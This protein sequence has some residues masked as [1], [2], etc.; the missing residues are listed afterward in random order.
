MEIH[1]K[2]IQGSRTDRRQATELG[3]EPARSTRETA[4][5]G[6]EAEASTPDKLDISS[7]GAELARRAEQSEAQAEA[8]RQAKVLELRQ[9][10][11]EGRLNSPERIQEA[12]ERIL[13]QEPI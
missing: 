2:N 9:A 11:L 3:F 6:L 8:A 13:R 5:K 4:A 1:N 12:A 10:Y 7:T